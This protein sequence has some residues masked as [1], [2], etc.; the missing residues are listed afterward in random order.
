MKDCE[1]HNKSVIDVGPCLPLL[2]YLSFNA[3][4]FKEHSGVSQSLF[5]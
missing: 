4:I 3:I 2:E 1:L 5:L